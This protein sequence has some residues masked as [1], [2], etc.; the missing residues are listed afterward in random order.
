MLPADIIEMLEALVVARMHIYGDR[1][2]DEAIAKLY[3]ALSQ[4][5]ERTK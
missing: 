3:R 4:L 2:R 1:S 5:M